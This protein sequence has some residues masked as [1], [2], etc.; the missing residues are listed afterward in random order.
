MKCSWVTGK[1]CL[2]SVEMC[3]SLIRFNDYLLERW[4]HKEKLSYQKAEVT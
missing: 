2:T 1:L 4:L 3:K